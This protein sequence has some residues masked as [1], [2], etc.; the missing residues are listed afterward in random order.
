MTLNPTESNR[1]VEGRQKVIL[2]LGSQPGEPRA[3]ISKDNNNSNN[4]GKERLL[5]G[6][7]DLAKH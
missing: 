4:S 1:R 5:Q 3:K 7:G 2:L 6:L